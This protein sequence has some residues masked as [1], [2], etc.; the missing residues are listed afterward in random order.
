LGISDAAYSDLC[1][2][3]IVC[4]GESRTQKEEQ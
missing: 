3:G 2:E 1:A 4:E